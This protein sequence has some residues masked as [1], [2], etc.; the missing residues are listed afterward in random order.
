MTQNNSTYRPRLANFGL[1]FQPKNCARPRASVQR[2]LS[3][4]VVNHLLLLSCLFMELKV[5]H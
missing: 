1:S 2:F 5:L 3:L 4:M